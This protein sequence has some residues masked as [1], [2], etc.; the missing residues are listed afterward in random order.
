MENNN[1]NGRMSVISYSGPSGALFSGFSGSLSPVYS[2]EFGGGGFVGTDGDVGGLFERVVVL[3][4]GG[5]L[6]K[7]SGE[8]EAVIL[9]GTNGNEFESAVRSAFGDLGGP[10]RTRL[11]FHE[12]VPPPSM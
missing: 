8:R 5:G 11:R 9:D 3:Q 6:T 7:I 1:R 2:A 4:Q 10:I 12:R